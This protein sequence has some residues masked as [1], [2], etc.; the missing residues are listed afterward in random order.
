MLIP[1]ILKIRGHR[2]ACILFL[3]RHLHNKKPHN[4]KSWKA[5]N[6]KGNYVLMGNPGS[7]KTTTGQIVAQALRKQVFDVD[8][9]L[10][11]PAWGMSVA[12][13][14]K[15]VGEQRFLEE[16]G[17]VL[18]TLDVQNTVVSLSGSNP[19]Q[20]GAM[21]KVAEAGVFI[22]LDADNETI[23]KRQKAMK[24]DRIVGMASGATLEDVINFRRTCYEDWY[25]IRV[26]VDRTDSKEK[27][28]EKVL[29]AIEKFEHD[30]GYVSTRGVKGDKS[31]V[32]F[33]DTVLQGIAPDGGLFVKGGS[34]PQLSLADIGRLVNMSYRERALRLL[35]MWIHPLDI[36]P[37]ELRGF[38]QKSYSDE[39]F[40]P[41]D[42][43]PVVQLGENQFVQELFHGPTASFKDWALQ[44]MPR[45]FTKA[46]SAQPN[47][48]LKYLLLVATSGDTGSATL[49]GFS[50]H[51]S[52]AKLGVIVL[53]PTKNVS[54]IQKWQTTAMEGKNI[55][56]IGVDR[57][58]DYCQ[59]TVKTIFRDENINKSLGGCRLSAANSINWGRLLPQTLYHASAYL[60]LVKAGHVDLGDPVDYCVPTGNFGNILSAYYVKEM[61]F[62][63]RKLICA[64]NS[65][66]I[67]TD[68]LLSGSYSP[69][70]YKLKAT[71]SPSIDIIQSSNLE[72]LLYHL[73]GEHAAMVS[74]FY[75]Q[76]SKEGTASVSQ[77]VHSA[78]KDTFIPGFATEENTRETIRKVF[79]QKG[80]LMDPHTAV[81]HY[82][83]SGCGDPT[84][85]TVISSTAHHGKFIDNILP[86]LDHNE[87]VSS[88][89]VPDLIQR[90]AEVTRQPKMNRF[91]TTM[92]KKKVVHTDTVSADYDK[93]CKKVVQ[94]AQ[95]L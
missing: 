8:D 17:K 18:A 25:D 42:L 92:V 66:K 87:N 12:S 74:T 5:L 59:K 21:T 83:L 55:T 16:E 13:K 37:Q 58:F 90:A 19:L 32:T 65:N 52:G 86:I 72:R 10:L 63:I 22:Y 78:L 56:V 44:L 62:P 7:G 4:W 41:F 39:L 3:C 70:S 57:D 29:K 27:V 88:L 23:L 43:A 36:S 31:S 49:D 76:V 24:V 91:L 14:L 30:P 84:T 48:D 54:E 77:Q 67:L 50:R 79:K 33:L 34:R 75:S 81:A 61:G 9:H 95:K 82:V 35:E 6:G 2:S 40:E 11:T 28:A 15:E 26:L 20:Y 85:P 94:F 47:P 89:S 69:S 73:S 60:D 71:M 64:S 45:F 38:I 51:A 46:M 93:I 68:F 80:Y 53:Y 1:H